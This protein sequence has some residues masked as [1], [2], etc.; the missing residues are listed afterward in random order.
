[1]AAAP[2]VLAQRAVR[3][4][5]RATEIEHHPPAAA[6]VARVMAVIRGDAVACQLAGD[7]RV[8][9]SQGRLRV[10][11]GTPLTELPELPELPEPRDG[12][13]R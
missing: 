3:T 5:L 13:R 1:M 8:Q 4:W 11:G 2:P 7:R 10:T 9:R 12:R 6:E